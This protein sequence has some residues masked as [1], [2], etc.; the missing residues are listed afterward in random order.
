MGDN[1]VADATELYAQKESY[2][3]RK[4]HFIGSVRGFIPAVGSLP[5]CCEDTPR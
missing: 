5:S 1:N 3:N 2:L 4:E